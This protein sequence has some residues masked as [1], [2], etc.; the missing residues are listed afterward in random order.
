MRREDKRE[1]AKGNNPFDDT[2]YKGEET[3]VVVDTQGGILNS[4]RKKASKQEVALAIRNNEIQTG[5]YLW[6]PVGLRAIGK[7]NKEDWQYTGKMLQSVQGSIQWLIG[8]W[9]NMA[10]PEYG[11]TQEYAEQLGFDIDTIYEYKSVSK[12][13]QIWVRTQNLSYGHH[14]L[15][16]SMAEDD[17]QYWLNQAE[18]NEWSIAKL[19][20]EIKG[21]KKSTKKTYNFDT[22]AP[23][24]QIF[25]DDAK[26]LKGSDK[27]K[28]AQLLRTQADILEN[29]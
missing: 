28:M 11:N 26:Q 19:R 25:M 18:I 5:S 24:L 12:S 23:R 29:S 16:R 8:D 3:K 10:Q 21:K 1:Q 7:A 9:L 27:L 13:V 22:V 4:H 14:K 17:Q 20:S 2:I 15:V 6:T